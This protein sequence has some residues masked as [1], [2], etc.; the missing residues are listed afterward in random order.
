MF[1]FRDF[2]KQYQIDQEFLQVPSPARAEQHLKILTAQ[3][4]LAGSPEDKATADY[5]AKMFTV[6][7]LETETVKYSVW[8]NRPAEVS[9]SI[10]APAGVKMNGP[11]AGHVGGDPM[12]GT[13]EG[14]VPVYWAWASRG[15]GA[16]GGV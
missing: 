2:G 8:M 5:V 9:V 4:H 6:A 10:T 15:V 14:V 11:R 1:G 3:P 12:A 7:G 13:P 16:E